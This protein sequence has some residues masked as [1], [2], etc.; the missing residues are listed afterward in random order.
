MV[1]MVEVKICK[2]QD[3]GHGRGQ[4]IMVVMMADNIVMY[5]ACYKRPGEMPSGP[6]GRQTLASERGGERGTEDR[7]RGVGSK[8]FPAQLITK[9]RG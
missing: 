8:I 5:S 4:D 2:G 9:G 1:V 7:E 6:R 3:C